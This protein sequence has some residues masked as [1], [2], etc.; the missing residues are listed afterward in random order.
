MA[1]TKGWRSGIYYNKKMNIYINWVV[2]EKHK[3][4]ESEEDN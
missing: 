4:E 2:Q 1:F 3:T